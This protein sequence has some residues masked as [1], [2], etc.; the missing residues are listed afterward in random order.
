M[1]PAAFADA[2]RA[3]CARMRG[4]VSSWG[5]TPEH[6][7][8]VGGALESA[9]TYWLGADVVYDPWPRPDAA[10]GQAAAARLGLTLLREGDHDHLQ[11]AT[12]P[13]PA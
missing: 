9:H 8:R 7:G 6:N 2:A 10:K 4:S 5:R 3:Y 11:P 1:T 13:G 12:W